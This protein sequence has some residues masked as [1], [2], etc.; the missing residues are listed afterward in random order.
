MMQCEDEEEAERLRAG[1]RQALV[2]ALAAGT[3]GTQGFANAINWHHMMQLVPL[4]SIPLHYVFQQVGFDTSGLRETARKDASPPMPNPEEIRSINFAEHGFK[5]PL[6]D[7]ALAAFDDHDVHDAS[8]M[9]YRLAGSAIMES[10]GQ[11]AYRTVAE[12]LLSVLEQQGLIEKDDHGYG[13]YRRV[14]DDER[15]A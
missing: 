12:D 4:G 7:F 6:Q 15:D 1:A 5:H 14:K 10:R 13:W 9:S 2:I 8:S 11:K 3:Y